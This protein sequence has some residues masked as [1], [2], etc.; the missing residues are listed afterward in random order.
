V[1]FESVLNEGR[2]SLLR[3]TS[4][5]SVYAVGYQVT[6]INY[7]VCSSKKHT[8][9][10]HFCW[11]IAWRRQVYS[12]CSIYYGFENKGSFCRM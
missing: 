12:P 5:H 4:L 9:L 3:T 1:H 2:K 6:W 8:F 11:G 7:C 10:L